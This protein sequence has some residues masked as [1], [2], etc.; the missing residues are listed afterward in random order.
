M[1]TKNDQLFY[2][3]SSE[4]G[5]AFELFHLSAYRLLNHYTLR[6]TFDLLE[7][8]GRSKDDICGKNEHRKTE[9]TLQLTP[10]NIENICINAMQ[11]VFRE[12][13]YDTK[14]KE[15]APKSGDLFLPFIR[16]YENN[17][18]ETI[19]FRI[20]T[21]QN[22]SNRNYSFWTEVFYY[23][24]GNL[25][26]PFAVEQLQNEVE[27]GNSPLILAGIRIPFLQ[28]FGLEAI[29]IYF[30]DEDEFNNRINILREGYDYAKTTLENIRHDLKT[31]LE[32]NL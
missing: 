4:I 24:S 28:L 20:G 8:R 12:F 10:K 11:N 16:L 14:R 25:P 7:K 29:S 22:L 15:A 17:I 2:P 27:Y 13:S 18:R 21:G 1:N 9:L 19:H 30:S 5:P 23:L 3:R 32:N 6:A 31:I 26:I